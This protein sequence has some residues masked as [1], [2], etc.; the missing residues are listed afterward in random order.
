MT[1]TTTVHFTCGCG[2]VID[3]PADI[4]PVTDTEDGSV[5]LS[6]CPVNADGIIAGHPATH[7]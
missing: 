4:K 2:Q 3:I 6:I 1:A 5:T 7:R